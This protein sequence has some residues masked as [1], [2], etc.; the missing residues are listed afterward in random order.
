[1]EPSTPVGM[2]IFTTLCGVVAVLFKALLASKDAQIE[3]AHQR[4]ER[5]FKIAFRQTEV[6]DRQAHANRKALALMLNEDPEDEPG[7]QT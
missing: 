3:Q 4:E 6:V 7:D 1:M 2:V 5:L